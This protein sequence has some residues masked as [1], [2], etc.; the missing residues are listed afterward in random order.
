MLFVVFGKSS[1]QLAVYCIDS[2]RDRFAP[3]SLLEWALTR[4]MFGEVVHSYSFG[5]KA[6]QRQG[7]SFTM[8]FRRASKVR[9][10]VA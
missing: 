7:I 5:W 2:C 4:R 1:H 3:L 6:D 8:I 9:S 10:I